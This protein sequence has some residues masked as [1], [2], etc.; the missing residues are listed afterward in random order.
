MH[1]LP[2][3]TSDTV[4]I[5]HPKSSWTSPAPLFRHP[6]ARAGL[7]KAQQRIRTGSGS[8]TQL[9]PPRRRYKAGPTF[10]NRG[11]GT[12]AYMAPEQI[13]TPIGKRIPQ[14]LKID[15]WARARSYIAFLCPCPDAFGLL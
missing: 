3:V 7:N 10:I 1:R 6:R 13:S 9:P 5:R 8:Y 2:R 11:F 15:V 12:R 14:P 4:L